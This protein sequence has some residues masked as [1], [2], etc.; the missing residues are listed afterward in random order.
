MQL[1]N[2]PGDSRTNSDVITHATRIAVPVPS[3]WKAQI[4]AYG[5]S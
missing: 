5:L 2:S 3:G 1:R 4:A